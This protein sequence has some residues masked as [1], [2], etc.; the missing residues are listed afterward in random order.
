MASS[1]RFF[2]SQ[3]EVEVRCDRQDVLAAL[4]AVWGGCATALI[5]TAQR[6]EFQIEP[7]GPGYVVS[8]P[9]GWQRSSEEP[10]DVLPLFEIALY[11]AMQ[12][13]HR[14]FVVLHGACVA[15]A[16]SAY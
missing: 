10:D 6:A 8:G 16:R 14:D 5:A 15:S 9:E 13:W 2:V 7:A 1:L 11:E 3:V 4:R 12:G